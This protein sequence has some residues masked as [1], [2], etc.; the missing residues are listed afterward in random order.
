ME[1]SNPHLEKEKHEEKQ[2]ILKRLDR[3]EDR[4]S[5]LE[6]QYTVLTRGKKKR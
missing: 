4:V 5:V 1:K 3:V 2:S 6:T